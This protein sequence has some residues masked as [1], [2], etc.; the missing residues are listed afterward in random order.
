MIASI[1]HL[2]EVLKESTS[3]EDFIK[4][5]NARK[6]PLRDF[7]KFYTW[8]PLHSTRNCISKT[9]T[10]EL[11]LICFSEGQALPISSISSTKSIIVCIEGIIQ[12]KKFKKDEQ[13]KL[14]TEISAKNLD[15]NSSSL[16]VEA[17]EIYAQE[18]ISNT[19]AVS[20]H[21]YLPPLL[22]LIEHLIDGSSHQKIVHYDSMYA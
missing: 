21:L 15:V 13:T 3:E 18:N 22:Y 9:S 2:I 12:T 16:V 11:D 4:A 20:L 1:E 14:L 8:N 10:Y 17:N 5:L 19:K 6:I 7:Q